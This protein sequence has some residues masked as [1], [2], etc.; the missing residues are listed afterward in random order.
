MQQVE[1]KEI[2]DKIRVLKDKLNSGVWEWL[3]VAF[4]FSFSF[5]DGALCICDNYINFMSVKVGVRVRPFNK[6]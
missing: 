5:A 2:Q 1:I 6:R 4:I 3:I